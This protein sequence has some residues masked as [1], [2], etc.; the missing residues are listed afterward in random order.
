MSKNREATASIIPAVDALPVP[1]SAT[2]GGTWLQRLGKR[3]FLHALSQFH[4]AN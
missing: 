2:A 1:D 4:L 3:L